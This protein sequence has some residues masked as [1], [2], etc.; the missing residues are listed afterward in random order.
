M[1]FSPASN[2]SL[3]RLPSLNALRAFVVTCRHLNFTEAATELHVSP[4]AIGQQIRYLEEHLGGTLFE[5]KRGGLKLTRLA[6][7]VAPGL[8]HAF[9]QIATT[10]SLSGQLDGDNLLKIMVPPSFA[11][12]WLMPRIDELRAELGQ[13]H[14]EL[15]V[16]PSHVLPASDD[17]DFA[18]RFSN[19][20]HKSFESHF[21]MPEEIVVLCSPRFAETHNIHGRGNSAIFVVP[22][23]HSS[24]LE[25]QAG[26]PSWTD[27]MARYAPSIRR[28][29][30]AHNIHCA[31]AS[32]VLDAAVAGAGLCLGKKRLAAN[33][34]HAGRLIEP[35]KGNW[36]LSWAY[37]AIVSDVNAKRPAVRI[38]LSW[39]E[40]ACASM[41]PRSGRGDDPLEPMT[42]LS[43]SA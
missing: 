34:I 39:L 13:T 21:L 1:T 30:A 5:R 10:L 17:T 2:I 35:L 16:A 28:K 32:L 19:G 36:P 14:I 22:L 9:E 43:A 37:Y 38:A 23:I 18:I 40:K 25:L 33:D 31:Q 4:T 20:E 7:N 6:E 3:S 24:G 41:A 26:A 29:A 27:W 42:P 11:A 12:R 15:I 8:I